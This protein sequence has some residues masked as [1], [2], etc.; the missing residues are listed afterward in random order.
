MSILSNA[1]KFFK[2]DEPEKKD[3]TNF[4]KI[5][6]M[7]E[8]ANYLQAVKDSAA[9][10]ES[11]IEVEITTATSPERRAY[12]NYAVSLLPKS[13]IKYKL[14]LFLRVNPISED[15][16][17][18]RETYLSKREIANMLSQRIGRR[19]LESD[20]DHEEQLAIRYCMDAVASCKLKNI[21]LVGNKN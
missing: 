10:G 2:Q 8:A 3:E 7:E 1:K 21:P 14:L 4:T 13:L 20:I 12:L 17:T 18:G 16:E 9:R 6:S 5:K 15:A 11:K 19:I